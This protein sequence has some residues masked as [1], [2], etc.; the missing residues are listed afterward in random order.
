MKHLSLPLIL[1]ATL[2]IAPA[3]ALTQNAVA[4]NDS[5]SSSVVG[6][7]SSVVGTQSVGDPNDPL[8]DKEWALQRVGA[9]CAW[10]HTTGSAD[11]TVAI[12]DSGVDM[13]HPDLVDRLRD[14]G[15]DFVGN[16]DDPSDE[17]GHGTNVAGIVAA[18]LN[19]NQGGVGLAP[20]VMILPV[21]VMNAKGFGS[22]RAIAR[23][24]RYAADKGA[25]V[26]NLSLGATLTIGADTESDQVISAIHYAQ[27]KGA[28]VVVAAGNDFVPL[29]NAIVGENNPDA[30]VVA[31]TDEDDV[32]ADFSNSGAWIGIAAPGVHIL[33]TMPTYEV[34]LTS[35]AVPSDERFEQ[36][37]DYM[38]GTS[39]ATPMVSAMAA[40]LFSAHPD[41]DAR[42]VATAIKEHAASI[43][44][45]NRRLVAKGFLGAGRID[46]CAALGGQVAA[47]EPTASA[48]PEATEPEATEPAATEPRAQ[49]PTRA[50]A[51]A[52]IGPPA[53]RVSAINWPLILGAGACVTTLLIALLIFVLIRVARRPAARPAAPVYTPPTA[54]PA[55]A[56]AGPPAPL[57][58][59][60]WGA[61]SVVGGPAQPGRYALAGAETLIGRESFCAVQVVGDG[62]ISRRH[63]IVR[64]DG[65]LVTVED[66][67]STHGTYLS[68]QRV[69][70]PVPVRRGQVLQV[71]QTLLRFE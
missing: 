41:W 15:R 42:Q 20:G 12:V 63:A 61:L 47:A 29:P 37:Y 65:R 19:N 2:L 10:Q 27:D 62:T 36:D 57:P 49:A 7:R 30:L 21:R 5:G 48:E 23:G 68:G 52:P 69:T 43:A 67:G 32:K 33:S 1:L 14:D 55:R 18:T 25:K 38:S 22:D 9:A 28:L 40:L 16:D 46:A 8:F 51:A 11:V 35:A 54:A 17:N 58:A 70:M 59:G 13:K 4:P 34:Y 56:P 44:K 66:A 6:R 71:G 50:P 24:V 31:A 39:Q 26:I 60:A 45:Q 53:A 3:L 64:N